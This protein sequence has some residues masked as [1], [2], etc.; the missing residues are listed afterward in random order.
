M[1][2]GS[3]AILQKIRGSDDGLAPFTAGSLGSYL[4]SNFGSLGGNNSWMME[5]FNQSV[6]ALVKRNLEPFRIGVYETSSIASMLVEDDRPDLVRQPYTVSIFKKMARAGE[7][8]ENEEKHVLDLKDDIVN[9]SKD[10]AII[11]TLTL[12]GSNEASLFTF[13]YI[14]TNTIIR[15]SN[16]VYLEMTF[17]ALRQL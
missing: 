11:T 9:W 14:T 6:P 4:S 1:A 13:S 12:D 17:N 10:S 7:Y 8:G 5:L 2:L 15:D 16:Y 3:Y